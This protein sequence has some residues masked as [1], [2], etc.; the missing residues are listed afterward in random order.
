L[1]GRT[2]DVKI[3]MPK[4]TIGVTESIFRKGFIKKHKH[5]NTKRRNRHIEKIF[6]YALRSK[7]LILP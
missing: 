7:P 1:I 5:T 3:A 4:R 2:R 6:L